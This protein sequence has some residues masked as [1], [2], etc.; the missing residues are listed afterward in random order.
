MPH[1]TPCHRAPRRGS[2]AGAAAL[3]GARVVGGPGPGGPRRRSAVASVGVGRLAAG[4]V[5][6]ERAASLRGAL[7]AR[8][9]ER[10][11]GG[12]AG[13]ILLEHRRGAAG[14]LAHGGGGGHARWGTCVGSLS[15]RGGRARRRADGGGGPPGLALRPVGPAPA[16]G[17]LCR[18]AAPR[19]PGGCQRC[20]GGGRQQGRRLGGQ[21][22]A[23]PAPLLAPRVPRV[24]GGAG[25]GA[26]RARAQARPR[27]GRLGAGRGAAGPRLRL[28]LGAHGRAQRQAALLPKASPGRQPPGLHPDRRDRR[29]REG[30][31]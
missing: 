24:R 19:L 11:R 5:R 15:T 29:P 3:C 13:T 6:E 4:E 25:R 12:V 28:A 18:P 23:D 7:G 31:R 26:A 1:P 21:R 10:R 27:D 8:R 2:P 20:H 9:G 14:G 30:G 22:A 17:G 16:R